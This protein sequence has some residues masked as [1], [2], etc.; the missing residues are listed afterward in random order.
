MSKHP[1]ATRVQRDGFLRRFLRALGWIGLVFWG[2]IALMGF[3]DM[4]R[5]YKTAGRVGD[6]LRLPLETVD[7]AAPCVCVLLAAGHVWMLRH[8]RRLKRMAEDFRL[9]SGFFAVQPEKSIPRLAAGLNRS[10][11]DVTDQLQALCKRGYFN[12]FIDHQ[13][14]CVRF[15]GDD[16]HASPLRA[17]CCPGCG[18]KT[19]VAD[20]GGVCRYCGS[21]LG[22]P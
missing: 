9:F 5:G 10:P 4:I 3:I 15:Y 8:S 6:A 20:Q 21:P 16:P 22:R 11:Q 14:Q 13:T 17:A 2:L 19:A 1:S 18:A 12:G 7:Y